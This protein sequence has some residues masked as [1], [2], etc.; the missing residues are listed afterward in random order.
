[1]SASFLIKFFLILILLWQP[2]D[3]FAQKS[4][5]AG[6]PLPVEVQKATDQW[7]EILK[8]Y[9]SEK[10]GVN[11]L[12]L[13]KEFEK[14]EKI[15]EA[16]KKLTNPG[17]S[18]DAKL[19]AYIN[20][21][22]AGMIYNLLKYAHQ[23]KISIG[24]TAFLD[25]KINSLDISDDIWSNENYKLPF[26]NTRITLNN[27]EHGLI[28][29]ARGRGGKFPPELDKFVVSKLDPRIHTAVN[30][31][32]RSCPPIREKA[33]RYKSVQKLLQENMESFVNSSSHFIK[34]SPSK[35]KSNKIVFWY[36]GDF[37]ES[38]K[39]MNGYRGAGDYL[40]SF[41]KDSA[42]DAAWIKEHLRSNFNDRS[43]FA[44]RFTSAFDWFYDWSINDQRNFK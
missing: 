29:N 16:Y 39:K 36:Y 27:I 3:S 8:I 14:L 41:V 34:V 43:S 26:G 1:M 7:D 19:A 32:A 11:Y 30:C 18:D 6:D 12:G 17:I 25:L 38:A 21:Y 24:S 40:A 13:E 42:K 5:K 2:I 4:Q 44:L 37:D 23:K 10:N 35:L 15:L 31:A 28:R 22:N 20:L 33:Y 9:V